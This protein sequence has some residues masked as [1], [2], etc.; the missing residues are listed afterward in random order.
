LL[1]SYS[2]KNSIPIAL[3]QVSIHDGQKEFEKARKI[4][5]KIYLHYPNNEKI[6]YQY[7]R[8]ALELALNE[9]A[10]YFLS[11]LTKDFPKN[12]SYWVVIPAKVRTHSGR[13][14]IAHSGACCVS[15][16]EL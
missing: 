8:I 9:I 4:I 14:F 5:H 16:K 7:G 12:S 6:R 11:S 2:D 1:E 3:E 13:S 10:L 15:V